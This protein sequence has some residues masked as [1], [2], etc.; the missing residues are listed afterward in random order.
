MYVSLFEIAHRIQTEG[1]ATWNGMQIH[2]AFANQIADMQVAGN[3]TTELYNGINAVKSPFVVKEDQ[4]FVALNV[5]PEKLPLAANVINAINELPAERTAPFQKWASTKQSGDI[6]AH[7]LATNIALKAVLTGEFHAIK[8]AVIALSTIGY[9]KAAIALAYCFML[10]PRKTDVKMNK[11]KRMT[12]KVVNNYTKCLDFVQKDTAIVLYA[13]G[14]LLCEGVNI[15]DK[16]E[17]SPDFNKDGEF[18]ANTYNVGTFDPDKKKD[19]DEDIMRKI[20][21]LAEKIK[22]KEVKEACKRFFPGDC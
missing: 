20:K 2:N 6:L 1:V 8:P 10:D 16:N 19:T 17:V 9:K 7:T 3:D 13:I 5:K 21:A 4:E 11:K 14:A 15:N 12:Y 18:I 22:S